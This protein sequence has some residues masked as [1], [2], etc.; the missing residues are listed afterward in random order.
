MDN[1]KLI[2]PIDNI[3]FQNDPENNI[4]NF[5]TD[6]KSCKE[7]LYNSIQVLKNSHYDE[8]FLVQSNEGLWSFIKNITLGIINVFIR[9]L[10]TFKTNVFKFYKTL[11]RTELRF[12]IESHK[13]TAMRI[14][15]LNYYEIQDTIT[16]F[17]NGLSTSYLETI[18]KL[19]STFNTIDIS[20]KSNIAVTLSKSIL[21]SLKSNK[22]LSEV[23]TN[24]INSLDSS[25]AKSSFDISNKCINKKINTTNEKRTFGQLFISMPDFTKSVDVSLFC[26]KY[27]NETNYAHKQMATCH[28]IFTQIV[29]FIKSTAGTS[30]TKNDVE[31]LAQLSYNLADIFDMFAETLFDYHKIEHNLVEVYKNLYRT[32]LN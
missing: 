1:F 5:Y 10:N 14:N 30:V 6:L 2:T 4:E 32:H 13:L 22:N 19:S 17:P 7:D 21:D 12:W 8:N 24:G 11:K 28:D 9:I 27:V 20:S 29:S 25:G 31:K 26:E 15:R 3:F 18:D 16:P 23:I